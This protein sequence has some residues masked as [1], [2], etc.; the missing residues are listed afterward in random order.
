L[1]VVTGSRLRVAVNLG[2][3]VNPPV[4]APT[5][6]RH[7]VGA[8]AVEWR[9]IV[10]WLLDLGLLTRGDRA[11]LT[12]YA[13][14]WGDIVL[15]RSRLNEEMKAAVARGESADSA[16]WRVLPSGIARES[17]LM[18]M[19]RDAEL[20]CDRALAHFGLSPAT[21]ARVVAS[22]DLEQQP[23]LPG[24]EDPVGSKLAHLRLAN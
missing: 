1:K 2:E 24:I 17:I 23:T 22:R 11:A 19:L 7:I 6:P 15:F 21:R 9:R 4:E 3:G 13:Q 8:A 10:P 12:M 18:R 14:A 20:R 5:K 16:L